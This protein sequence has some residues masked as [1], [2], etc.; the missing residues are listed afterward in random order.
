[1]IFSVDRA[2]PKQVL[3]PETPQDTARAP[4]LPEE[5]ASSPLPLSPPRKPALAEQ[6]P[7]QEQTAHLRFLQDLVQI[8][9]LL[10]KQTPL[11]AT[12]TVAAKFST[13]DIIR[14]ATHPEDPDHAVVM[15]MLSIV[16]SCMNTTAADLQKTI[17]A[18]LSIMGYFLDEQH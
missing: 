17:T 16:K 4:L 12:Q 5:A 8:A 18:Q 6:P 13:H 11:D 1:V 15:L 14:A 9:G 10:V 7:K 2:A 3:M